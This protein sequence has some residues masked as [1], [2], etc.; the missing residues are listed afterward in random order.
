MTPRLFAL[1]ET[2][3]NAGSGGEGEAEAGIVTARVRVAGAPLHSVASP[4]ETV[5]LHPPVPV[6]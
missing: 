4:L 3:V 6:T 1:R 5:P 2:T